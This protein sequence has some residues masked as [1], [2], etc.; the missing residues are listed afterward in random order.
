MR[1]PL[2]ARRI[3][4]WLALFVGVQVLL[5]TMTGLYMVSVPLGII[6]GDHLVRAPREQPYPLA[7]L[8]DP[9]QLAARYPGVHALRL[10]RLIDRPVYVVETA[11]G[12]T[13]LDARTGALLPPPSE[14]AIRA[15][16]RHW[17]TG[18]E[19]IAEVKLLDK[20][21]FEMKARTPPLWR[22]EFEGWRRPTLYFSPQTG[23]LLGRRHELWRIFDFAWML[24]IMDYDDRSDVNNPLLRVATWSA[25]AMA[26]SGA[27]LLVWSF[28]KRKRAKAKP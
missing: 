7:E 22:V 16:A 10:Q 3:H 1:W 24:H 20:V 26:I 5:W 13:L 14:P 15:L 11:A 8:L 28:P 2:I 17:Y 12:V 9:A 6:H 23:E 18:T 19:P 27:W 4:K 25:A 21:P